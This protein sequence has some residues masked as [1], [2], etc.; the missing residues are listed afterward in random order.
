MWVCSSIPAEKGGLGQ[1]VR[2]P[3]RGGEKFCPSHTRLS[4]PAMEGCDNAELWEWVQLAELR[5]AAKASRAQSSKLW[6]GYAAGQHGRR[7]GLAS[8]F[9]FIVGWH[10]G[11]QWP[12][13]P[14]PHTKENQPDET[15]D[16]SPAHAASQ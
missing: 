8:T 13:R 5:G 12:L 9:V 7:R 10:R 15:L 16:S 14:E 4:I 1:A 3:P 11:S 6:P 2:F